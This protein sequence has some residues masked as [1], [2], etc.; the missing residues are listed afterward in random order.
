MLVIA[1]ALAVFR[2]QYDGRVYPAVS[3]ADVPVG[4]LTENAALLAL[5][6]R[7]AALEQGTVT[8]TYADRTWSPPLA[9]LGVTLNVERSL[10]L[11][12][13]VGREE[14]AWQRLQ[15]TAGIVRHDRGIALAIQL[16]HAVLASWFDRVDADLGLPPH[17]ASLGIDGTSVSIIPELDGTIIDRAQAERRIT[18]ALQTFQ[19][20]AEPLPVISR[21]ARVRTDDLT[22][23]RQRLTTALG[24]PVKATFGGKTIT[25]QPADLGRF[26]TQ[27]IDP[28]ATGA[29]A[30][31]L[32]MDEKALSAWLM[33]TVGPDVNLEPKDAVVGWNEGL[34]AVEASADG[35]QLKPFTLAQDVTA[36]FF[37]DHA[38]VVIPVAV[39]PPAVDSDNLDA[40]GITTRIA[41]GDSNYGGSNPERSRN[42]EVGA[43][44]LNHT[45]IPPGGE[46]SFNRAIGEI[47]LEAG[48]VEA[49][50]ING[51][52]IDRGVGGGI[53]QV[54]TT[55][56]RAALFGGLPITEWNPHRY[57]LPFYEQGGWGPG[58]DA[59]ILQP[60]GDPFS[61]GDFRF[62]N[63]TNSWMLVESWANGW[64]TYAVI[65]GADL[66]YT[67]E[68]SDPEFGTTIPPDPPLEVIDDRLDPGTIN[69]TELP[70][71]G[72]EL[73]FYRSVYDANGEPVEEQRKFYNIFHSS[74]NVWRVSPDMA[75][76]S[77]AS[78]GE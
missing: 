33:E 58:Y 77:P 23:A 48:Y 65:Y 55:I 74:G 8:F 66:G 29:A 50:V 14:N 68:V 19:P 12:L 3:V 54:S 60:D 67:V 35:R 42:V 27:T 5:Q 44:L 39:M 30:F 45:L 20:I 11:A 59:S 25:L 24:A 72:L 26:V 78:T 2:A 9:D 38:N 28:A 73:W 15:S 16:D 37:G 4:G 18:D 76:L 41:A 61:G 32:G 43:A 6:Q 7:A 64:E 52:R 69:H 36:S 70:Q 34:V 46:F 75:G 57:R 10:D 49:K 63:P 47:T 21:I 71:E 31:S 51:E 53:C 1:T 40:L 22:E 17:D 56:F 62:S 13:N